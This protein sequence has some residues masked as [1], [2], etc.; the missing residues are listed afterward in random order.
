MGRLK[1]D[2]TKEGRWQQI[3]AEVSGM[4]IWEGHERILE[5]AAWA[6]QQA[7]EQKAKDVELAKESW[8]KWIAE[9]RKKGS[10]GLHSYVNRQ[11]E[12]MDTVVTTSVG[13]NA[14]PQAKVDGDIE[15]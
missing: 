9:E 3:Q 1:E 2:D 15:E 11:E 12:S 14:S 13:T 5:H 4:A 10:R 7:K 6:M 8:K